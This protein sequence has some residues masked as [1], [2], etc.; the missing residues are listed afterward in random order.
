M[1][2]MDNA[3]AFS[4]TLVRLRTRTWDFL[5]RHRAADLG[6]N[7]TDCPCGFRAPHDSATCT[8][9]KHINYED[10]NYTS[11]PDDKPGELLDEID[12]LSEG[13]ELIDSPFLFAHGG[14]ED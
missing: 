12:A 10:T 8:F 7:D 4:F 9:K 2:V 14:L 1:G 6:G 3:L 13:S 5:V 11:F